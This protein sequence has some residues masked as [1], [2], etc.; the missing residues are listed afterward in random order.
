MRMREDLKCLS[1]SICIHKS[2]PNFNKQKFKDY[3]YEENNSESL[4]LIILEAFNNR[5]ILS[6]LSKNAKKL[7]EKKYS[8]DKVYFQANFSIES[9]NG[10]A[11]FE[12]HAGSEKGY[13]ITSK[14]EYKSLDKKTTDYYNK[15]TYVKSRISLRNI[16]VVKRWIENDEFCTVLEVSNSN[17]SNTCSN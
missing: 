11:I 16:R 7:F 12:N 9:L 8:L 1:P 17:L 4:K 5:T 10:D 6:Q 3:I 14:N 13:F 15:I 2:Q